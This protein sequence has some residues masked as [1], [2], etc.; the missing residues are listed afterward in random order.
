VFAGSHD[1]SLDE[2]PHRVIVATNESIVHPDWNPFTVAN[3]I[4]LI[5]LPEKIEFNGNFML[6]MSLTTSEQWFSIE[7]FRY[8]FIFTGITKYLTNLVGVPYFEKN[9]E[10]QK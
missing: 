4:A 1:I 2:E 5:K 3:D 6:N 7:I 10:N 8:L 9:V